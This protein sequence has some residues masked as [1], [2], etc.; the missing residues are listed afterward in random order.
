MSRSTILIGVAAPADRRLARDVLSAAEW[1]V[2]DLPDRS[3]VLAQ[4][5]ERPPV[6]ILLD[7]VLGATG[8][9]LVAA[10]RAA[11]GATGSTP[12]LAFMPA[13]VTLESLWSREIDGNIASAAGEA[14]LVAAVELWRPTDELAGAHR[15]ADTFGEAVIAS[16]LTRF[17]AQLAGLVPGLGT[18]T[19]YGDLHRIAGVAGTLGFDRICDSWQ[20]LADGD[21][22]VLPV[23]RRDA[24]R[25]IAQIDRD[26][27]F[28]GRS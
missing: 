10:V 12:I 21:G 15:L 11:G 8:A 18:T 27:R 14:A 17:Q 7:D 5:R 3:T 22:A 25:V 6:L 23:A 16:M 24:R 13:S 4:A 26:P 28:T 19:G 20:R 1:D 9:A 2:L